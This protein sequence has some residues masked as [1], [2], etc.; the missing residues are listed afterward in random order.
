MLTGEQIQ[1]LHGFCDKHSVRYYDVQVELV[2]HLAN[3]I[4]ARME[5]NPRLS[6]E[7]ALRNVYKG[8]GI[9]GFGPLV[10][11]KQKAVD[12]QSRKLLWRLFKQQFRW[13]AIMLALMVFGLCYS[14]LQ[15]SAEKYFLVA[16]IGSLVV[17]TTITALAGYRLQKMEKASGKKFLSLQFRNMLG[18]ALI[19]LNL[20]NVINLFRPEHESMLATMGIAGH[21][22]AS[23]LFTFFVTMS[24]ATWQAFKQMEMVL[25][26][27]YP[28]VFGMA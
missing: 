7:D 8:F 9:M 11:A 3:A 13:P 5:A 26:K 14:L 16:A 1:Q 10:A 12:K 27:N 18:V 25:R 6:F 28:E 15:L 19:P 24:V 2:D 21:L 4:E 17:M 23:A 22:L 20:I